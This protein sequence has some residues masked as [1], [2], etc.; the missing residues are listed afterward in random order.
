MKPGL[1]TKFDKGNKI[2]SKKFDD[3]VMLKIVMSLSNFH[4]MANLKQSR[5]RI[6]DA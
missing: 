3:E 2:K 1:V 4:F 5:S 6:L